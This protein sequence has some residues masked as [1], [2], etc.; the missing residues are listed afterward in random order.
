MTATQDAATV[1]GI[2]EEL[3]AKVLDEV[4]DEVWAWVPSTRSALRIEGIMRAFTVGGDQGAAVQTLLE[5][6]LVTEGTALRFQAGREDYRCA[7]LELTDS[8]R[9]VHRRLF[10]LARKEAR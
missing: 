1:H 6:H 8:G 5:H 10:F 2:P 4:A 7:L 3:A 9:E